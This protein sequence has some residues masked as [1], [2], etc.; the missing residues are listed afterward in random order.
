MTELR[1]QAIERIRALPPQTQDV[2]ASVLLRLAGDEGPVHQVT[3]D[4]EADLAAA[5]ADIARGELGTDEQVR[6]VW[7][8]RGS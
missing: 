8:R 5:D 1:E 7:A 3:P 6:A 2:V 4:E